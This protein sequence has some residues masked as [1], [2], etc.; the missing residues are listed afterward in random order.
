M[1][2]TLTVTLANGEKVTL[3]AWL[4]GRYRMTLGD[5]EF[6]QVKRDG[7]EWIAEVREIETGVI[8]R[9]AGV[10]PSLR[11]AAAELVDYSRG[12]PGNIIFRRAKDS[13]HAITYTHQ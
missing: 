13:A 10:W 7:R 1:A 12:L 6:G 2:E 8:V 4:P 11:E 5:T 3:R 9:F